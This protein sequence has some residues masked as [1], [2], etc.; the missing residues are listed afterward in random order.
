[1][2]CFLCYSS[3]AVAA[4]LSLAPSASAQ[5]G[6]WTAYRNE[7][8]GYRLLYPADLFQPAPSGALAED[9][10]A[11]PEDGEPEDDYRPRAEDRDAVGDAEAGD[12]FEDGRTFVSIDGGAKLVVFGTYNS[13]NFSPDEYRDVIVKEFEG[14]DR[15]TYGPK[16][17]TWFVLSGFRG[18][19]IYYQKVM[20]SC[21]GN[22]INALSITFPA[23]EKPVYEPIIERIEDNFRPSDVPGCD[24]Q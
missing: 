19:D 22:V 2:R 23:S 4:S 24:R 12:R 11:N 10:E 13:E 18:D 14:Y 3:L 17:R 20:F 8:Y 5:D 15:I 6:D 9:G 21:R 7:R 1:M 16:G